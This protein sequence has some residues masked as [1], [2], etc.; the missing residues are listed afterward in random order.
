MGY[1]FRTG[2]LPREMN[3]LAMDKQYV[4]ATLEMANEIDNCKSR[5]AIRSLIE[6][7]EALLNNYGLAV[8]EVVKTFLSPKNPEAKNVHRIITGSKSSSGL[9]RQ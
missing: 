9:P 4:E 7:S 1:L 5:N 2:Y 8:T 6:D 3:I